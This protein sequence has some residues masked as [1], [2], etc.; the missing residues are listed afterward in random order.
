MTGISCDRFATR[1]TKEIGQDL[2]WSLYLLSKHISKTNLMAAAMKDVM[3][4]KMSLEEAHLQ[5]FWSGEGVHG[6]EKNNVYLD[7]KKV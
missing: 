6:T 4:G 1:V 3:I 2:S 5:P 7:K